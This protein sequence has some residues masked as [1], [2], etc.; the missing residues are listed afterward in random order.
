MELYQCVLPPVR[1]KGTNP[2]FGFS[3]VLC[4]VDSVLAAATKQAS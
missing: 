1:K 3:F 2:K 4:V